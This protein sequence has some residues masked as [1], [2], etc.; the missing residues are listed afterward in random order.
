MT[1][2]TGLVA[3]VREEARTRGLPVIWHVYDRTSP[4]GLA[5]ML[6]EAG[7][8]LMG[9]ETLLVRELTGLDGLSGRAATRVRDDAQLDAYLAILKAAFGSAPVLSP[10]RRA[11]LLATDRT[12]SYLWGDASGWIS[13]GQMDLHEGLPAVLLRSGSTHPDRRGEGGYRALVHS[14]LAEARAAGKKWAFVEAGPQS[15]PILRKLGFREV[16][17]GQVWTWSADAP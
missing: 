11:A 6:A 9:P 5:S 1:D 10:A 4:A 7:F 12:R 2:P 17:R 16:R 14:R 15:Q 3:S 8:S 13:A